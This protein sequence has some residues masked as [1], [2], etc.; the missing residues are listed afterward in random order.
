MAIVTNK[1]K[2]LSV[3]EK[4]KIITET[5]NRGVVKEGENLKCVRNLVS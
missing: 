4:I 3:E 2:V 1:R 5:E